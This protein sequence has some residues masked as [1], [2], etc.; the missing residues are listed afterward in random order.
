MTV[1]VIQV[2]EY[3]EGYLLSST[4]SGFFKKAPAY[5]EGECFDLCECP[6]FCLLSVVLFI[7]FK[8]YV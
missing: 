8:D 6:R 4:L 7:K 5:D 3:T 1:T 2:L